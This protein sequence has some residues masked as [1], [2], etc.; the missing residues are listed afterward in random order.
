MS[1]PASP[2]IA[3]FFAFSASLT[4]K[5][6]RVASALGLTWFDQRA[7][8]GNKTAGIGSSYGPVSSL[9]K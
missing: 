5:P 1:S 3:P 8:G 7:K 4:P 2:F 9:L 6:G